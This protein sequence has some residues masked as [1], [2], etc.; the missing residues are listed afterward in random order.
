[1]TRSQP[2][3]D[4]RGSDPPGTLHAKIKATD[5][6]PKN[7][8]FLF[9]LSGKLWNTLRPNPKTSV[10]EA[11]AN[12]S[13]DTH[14]ASVCVCLSVCEC[15]RLSVRVCVERG[16]PSTRGAVELYS[17]TALVSRSHAFGG[18]LPA[19]GSVSLS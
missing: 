10:W 13:S 8:R 16:V 18:L 3:V 1:M 12:E 14:C 15:V 2:S 9:A 19:G 5:T 6:P 4:T 17:I 11:R 7:S